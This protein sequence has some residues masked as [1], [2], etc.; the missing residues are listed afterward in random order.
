MGPNKHIFFYVALLTKEG[1]YYAVKTLNVITMHAYMCS[2]FLAGILVW[3]LKY[4]ARLASSHTQS[5]LP[6]MLS[7]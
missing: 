3:H 4:H 5:E 2:P 6:Y 1:C 7:M